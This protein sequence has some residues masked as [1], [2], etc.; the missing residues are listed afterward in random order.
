MGRNIDANDYILANIDL[1]G[2]YRVNYDNQNW[3]N[4][5]NQ[6]KT[7]KNKISLGT[8]AQLI[9]DIFNLSQATLVRPDLPLI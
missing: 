5:I 2:Y 7:D 9:N 4:I 3:K 6:L 8:R 1:L